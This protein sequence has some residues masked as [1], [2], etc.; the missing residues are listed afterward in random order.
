MHRLDNAR[1]RSTQKYGGSDKGM[2]Y[3]TE[4]Q[5]AQGSARGDDHLVNFSME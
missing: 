4:R 2:T 1:N 3:L 5:I